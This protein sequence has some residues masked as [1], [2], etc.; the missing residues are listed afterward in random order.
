MR[1]R[2]VTNGRVQVHRSLA[3][4]LVELLVV[5]A[6]IGILI[7]LLLPAVQAAREA[8]RRSNCSNNLKQMG[9][10]LHNYHDV[11]KWFPTGNYLATWGAGDTYKG[12]SLQRLL[13][14]IEQQPLYQT[15][16]F[17][18]Q[19]GSNTGLTVPPNSTVPPAK[20]LYQLVIPT[21]KCPSDDIPDLW[22]GGFCANYDASTGPTPLSGAG[23]PTC[24]CAMGNTYMTMVQNTCGISLSGKGECI[25]SGPFVRG[26]GCT[27]YF[28]KMSDV[29]DG[30]SNTI[31]YGEKRP[32]C[33]VHAALNWIDA[34]G[35]AMLSTLM[36]INYDTCRDS[37][38]GN[39]TDP[40]NFNCNWN[41]ELAF[42]S[43]HPGG[44]QF[45]LGDASVRFIG[46]T[47]D[48]CTL[49]RLGDKA[50]GLSVGAF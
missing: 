17:R 9:L 8:A 1:L 42:R 37:A 5:I 47:I 2:R 30:L 48:F 20:Y 24:S 34:N 32:K 7:A 10:A 49:N 44:A 41:S 16:D 45:M 43:L 35:K 27:P 14:Y 15:L 31:F 6:I 28:C 25:P 22:N 40:C 18:F 33:S 38:I 12:N 21:Y 36:P 3:F 13:P 23:S 4:T 50:D 46:Q 26:G 11:N 39:F 19:V 29:T